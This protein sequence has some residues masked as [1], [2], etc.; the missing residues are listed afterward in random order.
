MVQFNDNKLE[1]NPEEG[2]DI[3]FAHVHL[4]VDHLC[5]VS[6]Y[7]EFEDKLNVFQEKYDDATSVMMMTNTEEQ[8]QQRG[9]YSLDVNRGRE[10]WEL[11]THHKQ[12]TNNDGHNTT[13]V[14]AASSY[15]QNLYLMAVTSCSN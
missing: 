3:K 6:E 5:E 15:H 8:Q 4:Y 1:T 11:I 13:A 14:T 12:N 10:L 2:V 7:K 9:Y